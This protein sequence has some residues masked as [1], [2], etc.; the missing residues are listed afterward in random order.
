MK[1]F[2]Q[3]KR[4]LPRILV[5]VLPIT[6]IALLSIAYF[7]HSSL[8]GATLAE[9]Q[10]RLD[11][12]AFQ[13]SVA[14]AARLKNVVDTAEALA[15]NDLIK[16]SLV[17]VSDRDRY[18]QTLFQSLRAPGVGQGRVTLVDY[19]GRQIASNTENTTYSD[20][21]WIS[22]VM[23]GSSL[24]M[25]TASNMIVA[26]PITLSNLAEGAIV[27]EYDAHGIHQLLSLAIQ[28]DAYAI[29]TAGGDYV[30]SSD[31]AFEPTADSDNNLQMAEEW[32]WGEVG[33]TGSPDLRLFVSN[34]MSTVLASVK[35]QEM[36]LLVAI[37]LS[38]I[39]V[40]A[41]IV[42][43]AIKVTR[44]IG[45][46]MDG[47]ECVS[48]S[49][50]LAFRMKPF[51]SEEFQKLT[52]S[53][54]FM[55]TRIE[56]TTSS[57]DYVDSILNSM[58]ELLMVVSA[59][60]KIQSGNRA[61]SQT[62]GCKGDELYGTDVSCLISDE[63][64]ELSSF[65]GDA[66]MSTECCLKAKHKKETAVLVSVSQLRQFER[67]SS[68]LILILTDITEQ[69]K[70]KFLLDKHITDLKRSNAELELFAYVASHDLKAPLRA[71]SNLAEW[72]EQDVGDD[73]SET[74]REY[75]DLLRGRVLRLDALLEGLLQYA[76]V[77]RNVA[78]SEDVNTRDLISEVVT[79]LAPP[80]SIEIHLS[81]NL[82]TFITASVPLQQVFHN[83]IGNALKH[84]DLEHGH[85]RITSQ[86]LGENFEFAVADDGPGIPEQ[87]HKRVF[88]IFQTLKSRDETEGSG[89]GL[90]LVQ[91]LVHNHGGTVNLQSHN[92]ER[93]AV[94][95]FTWKK[96]MQTERI[97]GAA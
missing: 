41:S 18:I 5:Q 65:D 76:R 45:K 17:D 91:K 4:L 29:K 8:R 63:W 47:V 74:C 52:Q 34:R 14:I 55:L 88:K 50:D 28:A 11:H 90:A 27:I 58:N 89:M 15:G 48:R 38:T 23:K 97:E 95:R 42:I 57:R 64:K 24:I 49:A 70:S 36:F 43:T 59:D 37:I 19:R 78:D 71:I 93:G 80:E 33:L 73:L 25:V 2:M 9:Q 16:N 31:A 68:D 86:D 75:M 21:P 67:D 77:G 79:L 35:Q 81:E 69:K 60:G 53:F 40:A 66:T 22:D 39:A 94:F 51:G 96:A 12:V 54:N 6:I 84:H 56:K 46:F 87:Y 85:I 30:F 82:P 83:L 92:G 3:P 26:I 72:I 1:P 32:M 62:L 44:P 10:I 61:L 7:A 13:S 20:A